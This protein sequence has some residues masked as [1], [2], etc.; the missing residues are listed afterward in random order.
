MLTAPINKII[1]FSNVDGP[2]NRTA[3]FLQSCPFRCLYCHNPETINYCIGCGKCVETCPVKALSIVD[4]KVVW[5]K[6]KC[7]QCDTCIKICPHLASPKIE[8]LTVDELM[9]RIKKARAF[10]KGITVSGG[11]CTNHPEFLT[12]L[13]KEAHK[14]GLT[15]FLDSNGCHDYETMPELMEVTDMVMLDVKAFD[16]E[17]HKDLVGKSNEVVLK[18]LNYL[19]EHNKLYEVR[20]VLLNNH[21]QNVKTVSN[22][23]EII[24]DKCFYKLIKYRPFGV[25]EE[26]LQICG[27]NI[28][29]DDEL[30]A[31][32]TLA[33]EHGA[34][35]TKI[36]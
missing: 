14:L 12:E 24:K 3:I 13:F 22:V 34:T 5:D 36:V 25:R 17:F 4:K 26:G 30:N 20:T 18:N 33:K 1:N 31:M 16:S 11:E 27:R 2:G 8:N 23:A 28:V 9:T 29:S 6:E 21:E 7:V 15:C 10:I 35:N 19:L 32:E